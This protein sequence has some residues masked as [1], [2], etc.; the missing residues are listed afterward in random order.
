MWYNI[1]N[2]IVVTGAPRS[3]TSMVAGILHYLG[4]NMGE[5]YLCPDTQNP[6]GYF[7]DAQILEIDFKYYEQDRKKWKEEMKKYLSTKPENSGFKSPQLS[8][9]LPEWQEIFKE[10]NITPKYIVV[11]RDI[12]KVKE[13]QMKHHGKTEKQTEQDITFILQNLHTIEDQ[14]TITF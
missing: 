13:S 8:W 12:D 11:T 14:L 6:L 1:G 10:L 7:E 2:M 5:Y 9:A 4:V 3:G